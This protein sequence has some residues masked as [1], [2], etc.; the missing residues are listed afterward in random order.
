MTPVRMGVLSCADIAR[1]RLLPAM[2]AHRDIELVAVASRNGDRAAKVARAFGCHAVRGYDALLRRDDL[3]AVYV[4]LPVALHSEWASA[5]LCSGRHVLVEKPLAVTADRAAELL[6]LARQRGLVLAENVMFVHHHQ[7]RVVK[8]MLERGEIGELRGVRAAFSIPTL[9]EG[10]IRYRPELGGGALWDVGLYPVRL[11]LHMLGLE[12]DVVGAALTSSPGQEVD[13]SGAALLVQTSTGIF[14]QLDWGLQHAYRSAYELVGST[15]R[16]VV[17]RA[18]TPPAD[19]EPLLQ[20]ERDGA[21]EERRLEP[22]D[23]V[24]NALTAFVA[25]VRG[26]S[27]TT[28]AVLQRQIQLL[29]GI[30]SAALT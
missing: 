12:L 4:P 15:G 8:G 10:N 18:F 11:A 5:A 16:I 14:A 3:D 23:Q 19:Y 26:V 13:T 9:P 21:V 7:H 24:A 6:E 22:D 25:A 20:V 1:R 27:S 2:A 30:R 28:D 17:D 29:D